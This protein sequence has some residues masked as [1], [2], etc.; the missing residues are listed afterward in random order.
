MVLLS[1]LQL[2]LRA[3]RWVVVFCTSCMSLSLL[4]VAPCRACYN[5]AEADVHDQLTQFIYLQTMYLWSVSLLYSVCARVCVFA[6]C[7]WELLKN[8]YAW[9]WFW[10]CLK[11]VLRPI[12]ILKRWSAVE[13]CVCFCHKVRNTN[14]LNKSVNILS[15]R[16]YFFLAWELGKLVLCVGDGGGLILFRALLD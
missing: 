4:E 9:F 13:V 15:R 10:F 12:L 3:R 2:A 6:C 8:A 1:L 11:Y 14:I 5:P 16:L 7:C